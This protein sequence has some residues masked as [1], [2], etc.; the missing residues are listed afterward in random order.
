MFLLVLVSFVIL[1]S[2]YR[3]FM[4]TMGIKYILGPSQ[5]TGYP[6]LARTLM[7]AIFPNIY[8]CNSIVNPIL[9]NIMAKRFRLK[10]RNLFR[11]FRLHFKRRSQFASV[12]NA[13]G[14]PPPPNLYHVMG[15]PTTPLPIVP[16]NPAIMKTGQILHLP[17][18]MSAE[19][20]STV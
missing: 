15:S 16:Q 14:I 6:L 2:P 8:V 17:T 12:I 4:F 13:N 5:L 18:S 3:W 11:K 20:N 9:Y 10:V 7:L 19:M 1:M